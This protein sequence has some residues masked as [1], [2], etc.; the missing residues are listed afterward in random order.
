MSLVEGIANKNSVEQYQSHSNNLR[1]KNNLIIDGAD[2]SNANEDLYDVAN[3]VETLK[4]K[5]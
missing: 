3:E 2:A 5:K 1:R 4:Q